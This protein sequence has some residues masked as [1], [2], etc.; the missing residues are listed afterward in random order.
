MAS[1]LAA[2]RAT[3]LASLD[4]SV[5]ESLVLQQLS[6]G[7]LSDVDVS[8]ASSEA[9]SST[10][11]FDALS[12]DLLIM[13]MQALWLRHSG[14]ACT[15]ATGDLL[16]VCTVVCKR[17]RLLRYC[18]A[19]W[20]RVMVNSHVFDEKGLRKFVAWLPDKS[21]VNTLAMVGTGDGRIGEAAAAE[22]IASFPSL[23]KLKLVGQ[24]KAGLIN[25]LVR[26]NFANVE[27]FV[28]DPP[29]QMGAASVVK[30]ISRMPKLRHLKA[31]EGQLTNKLFTDAAVIA[32]PKLESIV[33]LPEG[34]EN[35]WNDKL[36]LK[37]LFRMWTAFPDLQLLRTP[38]CHIAEDAEFL[39]SSVENIMPTRLVTLHLQRLCNFAGP[40]LSDAALS[41]LLEFVGKSCPML[42][43]LTVCHGRKYV[44]AGEYKRDGYPPLPALSV[45]AWARHLPDTLETLELRDIDVRTDPSIPNGALPN[46]RQLTLRNC[47]G[48]DELI[49]ALLN[50]CPMLSAHA[51]TKMGD[52]GRW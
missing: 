8:L 37:G 21:A 9:E 17:W 13:V 10:G 34:R 29:G 45:F 39:E 2:K 7:L 14:S 15:H 51:C 52:P 40:H 25:G 47:P 1:Q 18:A 31:C 35:P 50:S 20:E 28:F 6:R 44:N 3:T 5:L 32:L 22:A 42:Y 38:M 33:Y 24:H 26:L 49:G 19:L 23:R 30:L 11:L 36:S 4:R 27:K 12:E 46:L 41:K 43:H 16:K 48:S